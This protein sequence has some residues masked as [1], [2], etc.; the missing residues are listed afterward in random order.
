ML[1]N[2]FVNL[3]NFLYLLQRCPRLA[4]ALAE[5]D[6]RVAKPFLLGKSGFMAVFFSCW[7]VLSSPMLVHLPGRG[8]GAHVPARGTSVWNTF[9]ASTSQLVECCVKRCAMRPC[10]SVRLKI[11]PA[12]SGT[13]LITNLRWF[14]SFKLLLNIIIFKIFFSLLKNDYLSHALIFLSCPTSC[15]VPTLEVIIVWQTLI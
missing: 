5:V 2:F 9:F 1:H 7:L 13:D 6:R 15:H 10:H 14:L 12:E 8:L 4:H 3:S 11:R